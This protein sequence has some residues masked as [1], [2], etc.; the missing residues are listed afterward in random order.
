MSI[1]HLD[2]LLEPRTVVVAGASPRP[3]SLGALVWRQLR[4]GRFAG[5]LQAL[6][7]HH[8]SLDGQPC[9]AR[10]ADLPL[11]P[12]LALICTPPATVP[13]L[14]AELGARGCRAAVVLT[15][16]LT[17]AQRQ[18]ALAAA[19]PH[20]LRLLG[21]A[22]PGLLNP[23]LGLH[24]SLA[25]TPAHPGRLAFVSQSGA[26]LNAALDWA[27]P[28]GIGFSQLL[29]L[30]EHADVDF[31]DLLDYLASDARTRAI[32]LYLETIEAPRKFMSAARAAA[33]NKP[34]IV[35]KAG[36]ADP[37]NDAVFE[38]ALRRA[39]LLRVDGLQALFTAAETLVR[40][41]PLAAAQGLRLLSNG[42][43]PGVLAADAA[44]LLVPPL[45]LAE[46]PLDI[47]DRATP[48]R[49]A[50]ALDQLLTRP[51]C[52][53]LMHAPSA[54]A[55]S[56]AVARA[57]QPL[58]QAAPGRVLGCWLGGESGQAARQ[59]CV[60]AGA[61]DYD[62]PEDALRAF[63]LLERQRASQALLQQ[64]PG[65]SELGPADP[66]RLHALQAQ[67]A[68]SAELQGAPAL[69]LLQACGIPTADAD[70]A[71]PPAPDACRLA[72]VA[73]IDPVFGPVLSLGLA[74][75]VARTLRAPALA[76]PP[77][78]RVLAAELLARSGLAVLLD[79][80]QQQALCD[81]L[82][83]V[84][85]LQAELDRLLELRIEPLQVEAAGVR[86]L[87]A[88]LRLAPQAVS[89][90]GRFAIAPYPSALVD[91]L[92]WQG[93]RLTLRPIRPDDGER[94]AEFIS[95]LTAQD[96]RLRFFNARRELAPS[97]RARLTQIDYEREMALLAC[98]AQG[99]IL[100]IA[101]A[102][103]D[104]DNVEVEFA[105]AVRSDLQHRGLGRLLLERLRDYQRGRGSRCL[106]GLVLHENGPMRGLCEALGF[107]L[108]R[109]MS[110]ELRY[111]LPLQP[112]P[113]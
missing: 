101:R 71:G 18:A 81:V 75:R 37:G 35:V 113:A 28:R 36:R 72:L 55:D 9:L 10:A 25:P 63:A 106:V 40:L 56:A 11:A 23:H 4:D 100:G 59:R 6:N 49:H 66:A 91:Q 8:A 97:E 105:L 41:D 76:L 12:D 26:L 34:V 46:A 85:Q 103:S 52:V 69:A 22:S 96:L 30:G 16:G 21:P 1:R 5:T 82:T 20:L 45:T 64:L 58:L 108:T 44:S 83:A 68:G 104:P 88:R 50:E 73:S 84:T 93:Q 90:A 89:G 38:A 17:P 60:A 51:G 95:G 7:P 13:D 78:N 102:A 80:A 107:R 111:E 29:A 27:H 70:D 32:L 112:D 99:R 65:R 31:G 79:E 42:A 24:A 3:G 33:R 39:G 77:L 54:F 48:Q 57:C 2:A 74:G 14:L 62:S 110:D 61:A 94:H 47:G 53:L 86:A 19:R 43:G 67:A 109:A 92:D 87:Q 98:D 15:A